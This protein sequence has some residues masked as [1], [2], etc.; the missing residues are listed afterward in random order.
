MRGLILAGGSGT[1]L[2]PL[3]RG[4]SKQLAPIYDKPMIYY[5]LSV[6]MLAGIREVLVIT[7]PQDETAFRAVL[8]DGSQWGIDI[9][10]AG[11]P[12][13]NGLA[14][15][16]LIGREFIAEEPCTLILGDN[17]FFGHG[18]A[19]M[20][21]DAAT[22]QHG[23]TVFAYRV[24]DPERYGVVELDRAGRAVAIEEKPTVPR[25]PWAV[26]GLYVFDGR[27]ADVAAG[28]RPSGRG[29]LEITDVIRWYMD[30]RELTVQRMGRGFAWFDSGTHE[31]LLDA[32]NFVQTIE[33]RQGQKIACLEEIAYRQGFISAEQVSRLAWPLT[34]TAY[35]QYLLRV[36]ADDD[37]SLPAA[38]QS[39]AGTAGRAGDGLV[40]A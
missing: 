35:G 3:T 29:E 37:P 28:V 32:A 14:E 25:T 26:T 39:A 22:L 1:R 10:Y 18:F 40:P 11:Q 5:P 24:E 30:R 9:S 23:G 21:A 4:Y 13:P 16:F 12:H 27:V 19:D 20:V 8:G 34:K 38:G 2:Y 15:A 33:R 6:L 36:I 31:S 7:R 17:I